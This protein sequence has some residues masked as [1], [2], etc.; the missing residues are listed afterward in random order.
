MALLATFTTR[1]GTLHIFSENALLAVLNSISIDE[2]TKTATHEVEAL[3]KVKLE[4]LVT[5]HDGYDIIEWANYAKKKAHIASST[6]REVGKMKS[7]LRQRHA[8]GSDAPCDNDPLVKLDPWADA[9]NSMSFECKA[10]D[11]S[12]ETDAWSEWKPLDEPQRQPAE[13]RASDV[14]SLKETAEATYGLDNTSLKAVAEHSIDEKKCCMSHNC[15][16]KIAIIRPD[17][18]CCGMCIG[19]QLL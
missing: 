16:R 5:T 18:K 10:D 2:K 17:G 14:A 19:M 15:N 3:S 13:N 11:L 1:A 9:A 12:V 7:L 8:G 4:E 6:C